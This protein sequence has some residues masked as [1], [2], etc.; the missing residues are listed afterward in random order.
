MNKFASL[1]AVALL[2]PLAALR[3][4]SDLTLPDVSPKAT[5]TQTIGITDVTVVYHR[6]SVNRREIWGKLVP[7]GYNY[8]NFGT[9]R[10]APWRAGANENTTVSFQHDVTIAGQPLKAG[11]YGLSVAIA[12]E[13]KV[14]VIFS[15]DSALW[16][17]FYYDQARDALRVDVPW[18]DASFRE[19]LTYDFSDVTKDTAVLALSWEK[20]RIP[21]P[22]K[23][24]TDT[25]VVASLKNEMRSGKAFRYQAG[26]DA[27]RYLVTNSIELPLALRW[28]EFALN[29]PFFGER[30]YTT[31]SNKAL[32]LEKMDRPDD[33][34]PIMDAAL[35]LATA[36]QVHQYGRQLLAQKKTERAVEVFK[37]NAKLHPD[38]WP[39]NYGLARGLSAIGDYKTA[40]DALLKAQTQVPEGDTVNANAIKTNIEKLKR[41]EDIN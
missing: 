14:T 23:T 26:I 18:E 6:P 40:L 13:G 33:A 41:G 10:A 11:T 8:L 25:N 19:Q 34:K 24:D 21:V 28:A 2:L 36:G 16:G 3:A 15:H 35:K 9:A 37:L 29:D 20:K 12:P 27:S 7:Y 17:S 39:V 22:I 5:V 31:L 30:N 4:Q 32:V 38:T 1:A